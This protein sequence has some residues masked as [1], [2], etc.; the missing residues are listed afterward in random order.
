MGDVL[1]HSG[2]MLHGGR[3]V[4]CGVL[5]PSSGGAAPH[6]ATSPHRATSSHQVSRGVRYLLVGFVEVV[7]PDGSPTRSAQQRAAYE[8]EDAVGGRPDYER[9]AHDWAAF[10]AAADT[11]VVASTSLCEK[12]PVAVW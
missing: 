6:H 5:R 11:A 2:S 1:M 12:V 7:G 10:A 3:P 9:L 8:D 4:R